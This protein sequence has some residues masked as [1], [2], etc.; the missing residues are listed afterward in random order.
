MQHVHVSTNAA[1]TCQSQCS[2][3][4]SVPMNTHM[5]G[6]MQH[7]HVSIN[8]AHT[9]Q[10]QCSTHMSVPMQ[11]HAH[12]STSSAHKCQQQ[13]RAVGQYACAT[14][15][16][17]SAMCCIAPMAQRTMFLHSLLYSWSCGVCVNVMVLLYIAICC[18]PTAHKPFIEMSCL[19][20]KEPD[21]QWDVTCSYCEVYNELIFDLLQDN[22]PP[23]DLR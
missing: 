6:P 3:H 17:N 14:Y 15:I 16:Q 22:S 8:A 10:Y 1:H 18:G 20:A 5:P 21:K 12:V 13:Y 11:H 4:M 9:C 19:Q 7:T 23:L 2:T